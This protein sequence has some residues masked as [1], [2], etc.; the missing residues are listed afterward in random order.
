[1]WSGVALKVRISEATTGSI[2]RLRVGGA[3]I[4]TVAQS[5]EFTHTIERGVSVN[6]TTGR[7]RFWLQEPRSVIWYD[8]MTP[9]SFKNCTELRRYFEGGVSRSV[10]SKNKGAALKFKPTPSTVVYG[11][12]IR[13]DIDKDGIVCER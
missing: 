11:A 5:P 7:Q 10:T 8:T 9:R 3:L 1:M 2:I 6:G 12:N 4:S 13:L